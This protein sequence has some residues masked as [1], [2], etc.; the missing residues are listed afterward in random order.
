M[1]TKNSHQNS[2]SKSN[3]LEHSY[4]SAGAPVRSQVSEK[5]ERKSP[6]PQVFTSSR[7]PKIL[8]KLNIIN[9]SHLISAFD[10]KRITPVLHSYVKTEPHK[11]IPLSSGIK[12]STRLN[13]DTSDK[14][15]KRIETSFDSVYTEKGDT[16]RKLLPTNYQKKGDSPTR[17]IHSL[18]IRDH[19]RIRENDESIMESKRKRYYPNIQDK[20]PSA[21]IEKNEMDTSLPSIFMNGKYH[22]REKKTPL[23]NRSIKNEISE[24]SNLESKNMLSKIIKKEVQMAHKMS[25]IKME[26]KNSSKTTKIRPD[27]T[28]A[29]RMNQ[30]TSSKLAFLNYLKNL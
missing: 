9:S 23:K 14:P 22:N 8:S 25:K 27:N 24:N 12:R 28:L 16:K 15:R 29:I 17:A 20:R 19:S 10:D 11:D 18:P 30:L 7:N 6:L 2:S 5:V 26:D 3:I 1:K 21:Q 4:N 13:T